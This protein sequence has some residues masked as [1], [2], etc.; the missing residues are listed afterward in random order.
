[1]GLGLF[2]VREIV[3]AHGGRVEVRSGAEQGT[4]FTVHL[5]RGERRRQAELESCAE[6]AVARLREFPA[7]AERQ[8]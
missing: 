1:V 8:G 4:T 5:P 3:R 7:T 2:I 6:D